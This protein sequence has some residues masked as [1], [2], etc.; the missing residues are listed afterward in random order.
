MKEAKDIVDAAPSTVVK[1]VDK[2]TAETI[3]S[4]LNS[5]GACVIVCSSAQTE[6]LENII[7]VI[8]QLKSENE[9]LTSEKYQL[10][11]ENEKLKSEVENG[12]NNYSELYG[13]Y[14]DLR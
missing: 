10:R 4:E 7:S 9:K 12:K 1:G 3:K 8:K 13:K 5:A 6:I 2:S 14:R 11:S